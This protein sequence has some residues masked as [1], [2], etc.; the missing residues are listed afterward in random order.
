MS[1]DLYKILGVDKNANESEIK[2]AYRA[3]AKKYHPDKNPDNKDAE[4]QFKDVAEAYEVLS[5]P[6]KKSRYDS[7]GYEA[8]NGA[9]NANHRNP[10]DIFADFFNSMRQEQNNERLK[11]EYSIVQRITLTIEDVYK[12]VNKKFKYTRSAKCETCKGKGGED[13][14][15]CESCNG[16]GI[17][18]R[19]IEVNGGRMRQTTTCNACNGRGF[20][21]GTLCNSCG[22][23]SLTRKTETLEVTIPYSIMPNQQITMRNRGHYYSDG[24]SDF[25]GDVILVIE[26]IQEKFKIINDY[27]LMSKV[28][29][30]YETMVLGGEFI[31]EAVDGSKIKVPVSKFSDIGHKLKLKGKGLR[32][33]N[34]DVRGD[35]Y[36]MVDLKFPTEISKEEEEILN[37]LKK[38]KE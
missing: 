34:S 27:G 30:P 20:K 24:R 21:I 28:D 16:Q 11:R 14:I 7:M 13:I 23:T 37:K 36:I 17:K 31:F 2:K 5:D 18:S 6:N 12:G 35:Q 9:P 33:P 10:N 29:V 22:G 38:L 8:Y 19:I 3:M 4:Q 25:Y 1:K 15:R 26:I 32:K